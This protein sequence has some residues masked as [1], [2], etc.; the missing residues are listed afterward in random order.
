MRAIS[1]SLILS[2]CAVFFTHC[3]AFPAQSAMPAAGDLESTTPYV[4]EQGWY[5]LR[6]PSGLCV[7]FTRQREREPAVASMLPFDYVN[8]KPSSGVLTAG[9]FELGVGIH[10]NKDGLETRAFADKKDIGLIQGGARIEA[11]RHSSV[12]VAG[13]EGVRDDFRIYQPDGWRSY[14]RICIPYKDLFFVFLGTLGTGR[15]DEGNTR[16]YLRIVDSFEI[17][18]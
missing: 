2:V 14:S 18:K 12:V 9:S 4:N 5:R 16:V 7:D 17:L 3:S 11:T 1:C 15:P 6:L 13:I 10:W 8:F